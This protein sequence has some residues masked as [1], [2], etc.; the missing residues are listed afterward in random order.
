MR[1]QEITITGFVVPVDWDKH[2]TVL[3]IALVTNSFEKYI[4]ANEVRESGLM[5]VIDERIRASGRIV[6][7][8]AVGNKILKIDKY[9]PPGHHFTKK[10]SGEKNE[11]ERQI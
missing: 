4:V 10:R 6:G 3:V 9:E 8:D 1:E 11:P 5:G 7:E 2:G